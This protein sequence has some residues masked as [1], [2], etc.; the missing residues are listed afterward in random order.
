MSIEKPT[1]ELWAVHAQGP[2]DIY[3]AFD[4]TDAERHAAELNAIPTPPGISVAAVVI[5]SPLDP[6]AHWQG[7]AEQERD[8]K[9]H[10]LRLVAP[11]DDNL[12][13]MRREGLSID[14]DNAYKRDLLDAVV[15]ALAF[16]KL[17]NT[18]PPVGHWL[19]DFYEIGWAEADE[20]DALRELLQDW[21]EGSGSVVSM[22]LRTKSM[23]AAAHQ[24]ASRQEQGDDETP[25]PYGW[26]GAGQ[27]FTA[28]EDA[29]DAAGKTPCV[30]VYSR[31]QLLAVLARSA[32][33]QEVAEEL[34]RQVRLSGDEVRRLREALDSAAQP[35]Q[36][37]PCRPIRPAG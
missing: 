12:S 7:V 24:P 6:I 17:R 20:R 19:E 31:P 9:L 18:P 32:E 23:L 16:G 27:F 10:L 36:R 8:H 3:P 13:A 29:A 26:V 11:T 33:R 2:D 28:R 15:G 1:T 14:G 37:C 34:A 35:C 5:P 22:E 30:E 25:A 4:L 21:L